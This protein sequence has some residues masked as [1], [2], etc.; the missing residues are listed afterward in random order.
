MKKSLLVLLCFLFVGLTPGDEEW[1]LVRSDGLKYSDISLLRL[2]GDSLVALVEGDTLFIPVNDISE[3]SSRSLV[4]GMSGCWL[5]FGA[6]A[7][8]GAVCAAATG[9][10]EAPNGGDIEPGSAMAFGAVLAS[11]IGAFA[12]C[13]LFPENQTRYEIGNRPLALKKP[14]IKAILVRQQARRD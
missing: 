6:G 14:M 11:P 9:P 1:T 4:L 2:E 8:G 13:L 7:I 12:G 10:Y 5:G 3:I